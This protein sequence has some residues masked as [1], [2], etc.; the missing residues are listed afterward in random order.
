[1]NQSGGGY[2]PVY[3]FLWIFLYVVG[4]KCARKRVEAGKVWKNQRFLWDL[5]RKVMKMR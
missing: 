4:G 5:M 2:S 1:M 3:F